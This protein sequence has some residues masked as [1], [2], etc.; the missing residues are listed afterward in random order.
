LCGGRSGELGA[1]GDPHLFHQ[2]TRRFGGGEG[3]LGQP[4]P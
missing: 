2:I 3:F 1:G 4:H